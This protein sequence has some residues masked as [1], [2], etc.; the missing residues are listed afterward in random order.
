MSIHNETC[1]K[2]KHVFEPDLAHPYDDAVIE[3]ERLRRYLAPVDELEAEI[4]RL[5]AIVER[6]EEVMHWAQAVLTAL[7][8]GDVSRESAIHKKLREVMIAYR[9]GRP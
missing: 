8:V 4:T 5:R 2:C 9:E 7:N 6:L 3:I 1:P